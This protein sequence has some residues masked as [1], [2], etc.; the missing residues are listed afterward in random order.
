MLKKIGDDVTLHGKVK[1]III[2]QKEEMIYR[3]K[4]HL[5]GKEVNT[6]TDD[7]LVRPED[8]VE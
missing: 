4:I 5:E 6:F 7:V 3:V 1:E 2:N 8:I